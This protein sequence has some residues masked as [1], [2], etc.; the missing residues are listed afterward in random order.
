MAVAG[1]WGVMAIAALGVVA[2]G[3][4]V[5]AQTKAEIIKERQDSM[6]AQA[7]DLKAVTDYARG[8]GDKDTA[9]KMANDLAAHATK[10][11]K[12]FPAGTSSTDFPGKSHAKP[13]LWAEHD[14]FAAIFP[15]MHDQALK[16]AQLVKTAAPEDV[17]KPAADFA[18]GNCVAC[19]GQYRET[20]GDN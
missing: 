13:A 5:A 19:H 16:L 3:S 14:K 11:M 1:K 18:K 2:L 15:S 17:R 20:G 8:K 7:V 9:V 12:L 6:T 10:D 4:A